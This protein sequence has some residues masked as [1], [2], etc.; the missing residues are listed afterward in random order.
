MRAFGA[1]DEEAESAGFGVGSI[2][3]IARVCEW[4]GLS[5]AE[6]CKVVLVPAKG[7]LLAA[8][9]GRTC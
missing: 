5:V 6:S 1:F 4:A 7:L 8:N 3:C 9:S 2:S